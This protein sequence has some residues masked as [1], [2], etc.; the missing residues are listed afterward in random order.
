MSHCFVIRNHLDLYLNKQK[1]WVDGSDNQ[2]LFRCNHRD[3]ALNMVFE[4]S[5]K[6]IELRAQMIDCE[7]NEK[8]HPI[9]EVLTKIEAS[10]QIELDETEG[11]TPE[12]VESL[13]CE[14]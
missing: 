2:S 1:E 7:L 4:L 13:S 6:D 11:V 8:K 10:A 5:S 14:E 9:V 12:A 3:E